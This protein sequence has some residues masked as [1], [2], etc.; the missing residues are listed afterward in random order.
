MLKREEN[1]SA[2]VLDSSNDESEDEKDVQTK[3]PK[4][5]KAKTTKKAGDGGKDKPR[6]VCFVFTLLIA[7]LSLLNSV[8]CIRV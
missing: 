4:R 2:K 5:K 8:W 6:R 7:C 3:P 1:E